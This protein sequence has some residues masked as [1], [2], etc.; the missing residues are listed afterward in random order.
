MGDCKGGEV[1]VVN[2]ISVNDRLPD[3]IRDVLTKGRYGV[4][5][6]CFEL[7]SDGDPCWWSD[8]VRKADFKTSV[9]HWAELDTNMTW[10]PIATCPLDEQPMDIWSPE[11]GRCTD[12]VRV[13]AGRGN[14]WWTADNDDSAIVRDAT[15]WMRV[16]APGGGKRK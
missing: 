5:T 16:L 14:V 4:H 13:D 6:A 15:H 1:V 3:D 2:W 12:M 11:Y 7:G 9:T 8:E 10:Q